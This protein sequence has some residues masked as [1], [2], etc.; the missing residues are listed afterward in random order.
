[1]TSR[2]ALD[3][4]SMRQ[5]D[6]GTNTVVRLRSWLCGCEGCSGPLSISC[7]VITA[8]YGRRAVRLGP[9]L[10]GGLFQLMLPRLCFSNYLDDV[11]AG[12]LYPFDYLTTIQLEKNNRCW[13]IL[14]YILV[15]E[16]MHAVLFSWPLLFQSAPVPLSA[17]FSSRSFIK[18]LDHP[19]FLLSMNFNHLIQTE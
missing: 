13:S 18:R 17:S 7:L 6:S 2:L 14:P 10:R 5:V 8:F 16:I 11:L 15:C 1:M 3:C 12:K 19:I 4:F 9:K